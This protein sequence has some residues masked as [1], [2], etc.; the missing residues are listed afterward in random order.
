MGQLSKPRLLADTDFLDSFSS[1]S[2]PLDYWLRE[3][4]RLA[5]ATNTARVYV[6]CDEQE[7]VGYFAL[8][9][10]S[11]LREDLPRDLRGNMPRHRIPLILLARL[12]VAR[13]H[14][15]QGIGSALV[16]SALAISIS[17]ANQVGAMGLATNAKGP[18]AKAFYEGLRFQVSPSDESLLV[19]P[20]ARR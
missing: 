16:S 20:L 2:V 8:A 9:A 7:V 1:G 5:S 12:A 18:E 15:H 3:K 6:V 11:A 10:A 19:F 17:V 13:R 14:Q 4:A